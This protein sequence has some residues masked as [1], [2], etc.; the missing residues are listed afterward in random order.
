MVVLSGCRSATR[1]SSSWRRC[2]ASTPSCTR[3]PSSMARTGSQRFRA[4]TLGSD[5]PRDL[6]GHAHLHDRGAQGVRADLRAHPRRPG[7]STLVPSY[8]SYSEFFQSQQVGYGA[9]IATALTILIGIVAMLFIRAQDAAERAERAGLMAVSRLHRHARPPDRVRARARHSRRARGRVP[10][11]PDPHQ[12]VQVAGRLR[13]GRPARPADVA[14]LRRNRRILGARRLPAQGV[15]LDLHLRHRRAARGA[16]LGAQRVRDRHRAGARPHVGD[17]R[18]SCSPT[19]CRRRPCSTRCTS[20]SS[21]W[22]CTT[23]R[24]RWSSCSR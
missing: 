1:W 13:R 8:Y 18:C 23:I 7:S 14:V 21:R 22:G 17:R 19:C 5:P 2:S 12:L 9:T 4:I 6:R 11:L 20:S 10:V 3:P 24:G 15:E 16:H